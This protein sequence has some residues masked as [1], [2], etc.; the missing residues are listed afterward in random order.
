MKI[1]KF[2]E[3]YVRNYCGKRKSCTLKALIQKKITDNRTFWKTVVSLFT[4]KA[5]RG[6]KTILTE[7]EKHISDD[8]KIFKIFNNFFSN[9]V[10]DL[11]IPDY[12]NY[13]PQKTHALFQLSLKRLKNTPV[14]SILKKGNLIQYFHSERLLKKRC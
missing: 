10:L 3:T 12:C 4:N 11:K 13:L 7:A 6:E 2:S 5:S 8:K 14:F 9:I 1:I